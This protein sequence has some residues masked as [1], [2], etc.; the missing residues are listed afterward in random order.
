[1]T[2]LLATALVA[3]VAF[4]G[5]GTRKI[6][7]STSVAAATRPVTASRPTPS[8]PKPVAVTSAPPSTK[9]P[10][11]KVLPPPVAV[12]VKAPP[13]PAKAAVLTA[14]RPAVTAPP[15]TT[16][17]P[18]VTAPAPAAPPPALTKVAPPATVVAPTSPAN[19]PASI[20]P[21]QSFAFACYASSI[22]ISSCDS[23]ALAAINQAR[24]GEGLGPLQL[25]GDFYSLDTQG[26]LIAVSDAERTSRGLPAMGENAALDALALVGAVAGGDPAG[27]LGFAWASIYS[28]GEPTALA[29]D[30]T[31]MYDDGPGSP[32]LDC[33]GAGGTGC[34]GHRDNI[35]SPWSGQAGAGVSALGGRVTLTVV[36]VENF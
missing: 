3:G 1:M 12:T 9:S 16:P 17:R 2:G 31:W 25:P 33:P 5:A 18:A 32:N 10:A 30:Y 34:W 19:P 35:L 24:T 6:L 36:F 21:S 4:G 14:P 7:V 13:A 22:N 28:L 26:Q 29:A 15:R 20:P 11:A 8:I 27:P 23:A